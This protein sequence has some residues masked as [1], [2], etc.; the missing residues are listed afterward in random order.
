MQKKR[1]KVYSKFYFN[2]ALLSIFIWMFLWLLFI[3]LNPHKNFTP[4]L[5]IQIYAILFILW[6]F[7]SFLMMFL[8]KIVFKTPPV[9][10][11]TRKI[12]FILIISYWYFPT[13][14]L[15]F[16]AGE[17]QGIL[18]SILPGCFFCIIPITFIIF[19]KLKIK[20]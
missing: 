14:V 17:G 6:V 16:F 9:L 19:L 12:V 13:H 20:R 3:H 15:L 5:N 4:P 7:A 18:G 1:K 11:L 10:S 2:C 8:S